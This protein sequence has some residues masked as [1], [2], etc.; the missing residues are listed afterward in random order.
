MA[1]PA[2]ATATAAAAGSSP[3]V[4]ARR[5]RARRTARLAEK[6]KWVGRARG[7]GGE[8]RGGEG[9]PPTP[10]PPR[11]PPRWARGGK[12]GRAGVALPRGAPGC[13]AAGGGVEQLSEN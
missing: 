13:A 6:G 8:G 11:P 4:T 12:L 10:P 2:A 1:P 3:L 5:G 9:A 7:R